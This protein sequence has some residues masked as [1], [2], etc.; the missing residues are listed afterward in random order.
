M[1]NE[2][3]LD[4]IEMENFDDSEFEDDFVDDRPVTYHAD[5]VLPGDDFEDMNFIFNEGP[6][7]IHP[8]IRSH[9]DLQGFDLRWIRVLRPGTNQEDFKNIQYVKN[10]KWVFVES[11]EL[12]EFGDVFGVEL[13]QKLRTAGDASIIQVGDC[14]LVKRSKQI[15]ER[16][17]EIKR[18]RGRER[19]EAMANEVRRKGYGYE[20]KSSVDFIKTKRDVSFGGDS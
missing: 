4:Q 9:F 7:D 1:I 3:N 17:R 13:G 12:E 16:I 2:E 5:N 14:A 6:L 18:V 10:R 8:S 19:V 11:G 15:S 20:N